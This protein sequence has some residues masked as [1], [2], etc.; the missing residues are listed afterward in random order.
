MSYFEEG[1]QGSGAPFVKA[2]VIAP[3][4]VDIS[5]AAFAARD[6]DPLR[7]ALKSAGD[8]LEEKNDEEEEEEEEGDDATGIFSKIF[9]A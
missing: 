7:V 2:G 9:G 4:N 5:E 3:Q 8:A 1:L 6:R